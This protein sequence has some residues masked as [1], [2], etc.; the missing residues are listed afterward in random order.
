MAPKRSSSA[1][2]PRGPAAGS[3]SLHHCAR[4]TNLPLSRTVTAPALS[5][6]KT[7]WSPS[8][9]LLGPVRTSSLPFR[10]SGPNSRSC[11]SSS[12][13]SSSSP[14]ATYQR[15]TGAGSSGGSTSGSAAGGSGGGVGAGAGRR[16]SSSSWLSKLAMCRCLS[17]SCCR[18]FSISASCI[19]TCEETCI[20][21]CLHASASDV[22][23]AARTS[24]LCTS[25]GRG[26]AW[27]RLCSSWTSVVHSATRAA[28]S[29][30]PSRL[31]CSSRSSCC[32]SAASATAWRS[33]FS[34]ACNS[35]VSVLL[36]AASKCCCSSST[37]AARSAAA[38]AACSSPRCEA[39]SSWTWRSCRCSTAAISCHWDSCCSTCAA[40]SRLWC[41]C[42]S[43]RAASSCCS[44][45]CRST[46]AAIS[47]R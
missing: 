36:R 8:L 5:F 34:Q 28:I 18:I 42:S 47:C 20:S 15:C 1:R 25:D 19:R 13:S 33:R 39:C 46:R 24:L 6:M 10:G 29:R 14:F 16:A 27:A 12:W 9:Y 3:R 17:T 31:R 45:S 41:S 7:R 43:M 11:A 40:S 35:C 32:I 4:E 21:D 30:S 26:P 22:A 38:A 23:C 2:E 37:S 44:R